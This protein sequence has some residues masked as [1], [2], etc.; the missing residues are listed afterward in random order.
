MDDR[1]H[2]LETQLG[3]QLN[4]I[5]AMLLSIEDKLIEQDQELKRNQRKTMTVLT[6]IR[7]T[8]GNG[9]GGSTSHS[10]GGGSTTTDDTP[11]S[12]P[13]IP[14]IPHRAQEV[15][16]DDDDN[17]VEDD[18]AYGLRERRRSHRGRNVNTHTSSSDAD[19][20]DLKSGRVGP[21]SSEIG[22]YNSTVH[23]E[24]GKRVF[25]FYWIVTGMAYKINNWSQ[26]RVLR[27]NSFYTNSR[28]YRLFMKMIPKYS[29]T[30]M[31][32]HVGITK[33]DY[34]ELL[35]W[36][37]GLKMKLSVLDQNDS[38]ERAQDM[39]SRLWDPKELCSGS[40]WVKPV[41]GDNP[42]CFGLGI[43]HDAIKTRNYIWNDRMILKLIVFLD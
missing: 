43:P 7:R 2:N 1:F 42:E 17:D 25:T 29:A 11:Y 41:V 34:D 19:I 23:V 39:H 8:N 3:D 6:G 22:T 16:E 21:R 9:N 24:N 28:G 35:E 15:V 38:N 5:K 30:T 10:T 14:S 33:G 20:V 36:P 12:P 18:S 13:Y 26:Q 40:N 27:S 31:F 32:L 37:F 4:V